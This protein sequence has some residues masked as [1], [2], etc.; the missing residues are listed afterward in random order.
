MELARRNNRA[1]LLIELRAAL[2]NVLTAAG[3]TARIVA[4]QFR[5][6]RRGPRGPKRRTGGS[7]NQSCSCN[8]SSSCRHSWFFRTPV[9]SLPFQQ[10]ADR[11]RDLGTGA[12]L[13][14]DFCH[15]ISVFL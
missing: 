1:V 12:R 6:A 13:K 9:G 3:I 15:A 7:R 5:H 8:R 4:H 11:A 2:V 14:A 10:L